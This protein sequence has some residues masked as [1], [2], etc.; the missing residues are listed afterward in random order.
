MLKLSRILF[1]LTLFAVPLA[2]Q[3]TSIRGR[4]AL[5][6]GEPLPGVTVTAEDLGVTALTGERGEYVRAIPAGTRG[7]VRVTVTLAG[8]QTRTEQVD[9]S[10]GD[11][12]QNFTLRVSFGEQITVGSRA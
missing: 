10:G 5:P 8:F 3:T 11:A 7:P 12:T 2:A 6:E 1:V 9:I 4:V